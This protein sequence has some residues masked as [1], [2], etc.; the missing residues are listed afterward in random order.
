MSYN[1]YNIH[2]VE[3]RRSNHEGWKNRTCSLLR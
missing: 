1:I 3:Q 2:R